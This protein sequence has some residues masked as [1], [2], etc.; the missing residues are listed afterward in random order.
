MT[1]ADWLIIGLVALSAVASLWRGFTREAISLGA[2]ITAFFVATMFAPA[3]GVALEDIVP[4]DQ[5]RQIAAFGI[6]FVLTLIAGSLLGYV[7]GQLIRATGLGFADR[8]LGMAFGL[9]RGVILALAIVMVANIALDASDTPRPAWFK[10]SL[11]VPHLLLLE[12][13]ARD[14]TARLMDWLQG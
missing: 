7:L 9:V 1:L 3:M 11:L 6:L 10:D 4:H 5:G 13:W 8:V 12:D 2:W 14:G